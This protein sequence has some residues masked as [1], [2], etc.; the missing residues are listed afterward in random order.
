ML[1]LLTDETG[2]GAAANGAGA[3][4]DNGCTVADAWG[5]TGGGNASV[6]WGALGVVDHE[7]GAEGSE[8]GCGDGAI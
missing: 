4:G 8:N 7:G 5:T 3:G 2:T 1:L 6:A